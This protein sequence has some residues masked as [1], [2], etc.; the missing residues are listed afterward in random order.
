MKTYILITIGLL[1]YA[2]LAYLFY[3]T[4]VWKQK[5]EVKRRAGV[6]KLSDQYITANGDIVRQS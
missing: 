6:R 1:M 3:Y 5:Q 2:A 4:F